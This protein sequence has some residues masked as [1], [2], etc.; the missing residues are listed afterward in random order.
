MRNAS[1]WIVAAVAA[2]MAAAGC[3]GDGEAQEPIDPAATVTV[4]ATPS[5]TSTSNR[6]TPT[7]TLA[8]TEPQ[9]VVPKVGDTQQTDLGAVTVYKVEFPASDPENQDIA[10]KGTAPAVVDLKAC[11]N[12]TAT[13]DGYWFDASSFLLTD[14]GGRNYS[15]WNVQV[16]AREPNLTDALPLDAPKGGVCRRGWLTFEL[17]PKAEIVSVDYGPYEGAGLSWATRP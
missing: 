13:S 8:D 9:P 5:Q 16:G 2:C 15:Y 17:P 14:A 4:T 6:P 3:G 7:P 12:G 11:G 10:T 1:A